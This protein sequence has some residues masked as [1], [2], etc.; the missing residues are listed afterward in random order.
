MATAS[1]VLRTIALDGDKRVAFRTTSGKGEVG[2]DRLGESED[3]AIDVMREGMTTAS[4]HVHGLTGL[5]DQG[6]ESGAR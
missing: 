1:S 3:Y 2:F 4:L 5:V 6:G